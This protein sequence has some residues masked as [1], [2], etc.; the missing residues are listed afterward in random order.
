MK[1][2]Q[3]WPKNTAL[4]KVLVLCV[5]SALCNQALCLFVFR[6]PVRI[7]LY[8][9]T[10]FTVAMCFSAGFLPAFLA[11]AV[12]M[13][14]STPLIYMFLL[15]TTYEMSVV[16][17]MVVNIFALCI[18]AEIALVCMYH[19]KM[20]KREAVFLEKPSLHSFIGMAPLLLGLVA[21][22]C[23]VISFLGG[24]IDFGLTLYSAPRI[25]FPE[26]SFKLGLLRNNV[27]LLATAILSRIP[28]NIVDRFFAVFGGYGIS[29][30]YRKWLVH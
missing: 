15:G 3:L 20:K 30:L 29:L 9:D 1:G 19:A 10:V 24:F 28:I 21:L 18:I 25:D 8:L 13:P 14:L 22:D 26:D 6:G 12:I 5:L 23:I 27:P 16:M 7:P 4:W 2:I 11:G 17:S